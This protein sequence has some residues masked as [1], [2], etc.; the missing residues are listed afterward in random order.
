MRRRYGRIVRR[1]TRQQVFRY[2]MYTLID[3]EGTAEAGQPLP[4]RKD[5]PVLWHVMRQEARPATVRDP[6]LLYPDRYL[7]DGRCSE[8]VLGV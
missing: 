6:C 5:T 4:E 1:H 7:W 2:N 3:P 8:Y